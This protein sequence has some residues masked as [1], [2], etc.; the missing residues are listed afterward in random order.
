MSDFQAIIVGSGC[1]G[2]V[3][4]YELA[5]DGKETLVVERGN[6][7]GAKNMTGGRLYSPALEAIFPDFRDEAPLERRISH[8][9]LSFLTADACTTIDFSSAALLQNGQDS[10]SV[11][12]APFDAWLSS[13]AEAAGAEYINGIAVEELLKDGERVIGIKA[14]DDEISADVVVL[15]DGCNS[16]LTES[17]V[18]YHRPGP[19]TLAAGIK[20]IIAL[21][22][23]TVSDRTGNRA[24]EG[25]AWLFVGDATKG[26][27]GGGFIY[28][29]RESIS[30]GLVATLSDLA[31]SPY[32]LCQMLED[33]KAHPTVEPL[34]AGGT[35]V[36]HSGHM[37]PEGGLKMMPDLTGDGVLLAGESAMICVNLGYRVRGMDYA[38][39]AGM[40]AGRAA[41]AALDAGD[42]S[43]AGLAGYQTA[44]EAS[45]VLQ[46][47]RQF[48]RFPHFLESTPR[49]FR[50]YPE[51]AR[52]AFNRL[53][54]VDGQPDQPLT[55]S[56][57]P[58]VKSLG[59][60]TLFRDLRKG[61]KSL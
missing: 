24:G 22:E 30:V 18:G 28:S 57:K 35:V 31:R 36:E 39:A 12:R 26:H 41:A 17:A 34:L 48:Q 2:A 58:L 10:Y 47:M 25:T 53:F 51:F 49:L 40:H 4:A 50:E 13:K 38:L 21:D 27:T 1:A 46:D 19:Q 5:R 43:R 54:V 11:L 60:G 44:L 29:N 3:A 7:N 8:E 45:F 42:T 55:K 37:V 6:S 61:L 9:R 15:A 52:D 14:G 56:L 59:Y 16:L 20:Q 32:S 23:Q 33:F